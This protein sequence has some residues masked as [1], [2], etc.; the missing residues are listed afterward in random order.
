MMLSTNDMFTIYYYD[1][2]YD[3]YDYYEY[4]EY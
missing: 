4:Y 1:Y 2:D 3:E